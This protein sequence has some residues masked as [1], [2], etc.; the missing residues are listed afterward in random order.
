MGR[1]RVY[2][3]DAMALS[4]RPLRAGRRRFLGAAAALA[5]A[6]AARAGAEPPIADAH[7][8]IGMFSSRLRSLRAEMEQAG[9]TLLA[10]SIVGDTPW[11]HRTPRGI[12]Q[13]AEPKPGEQA[14]HF[15]RRLAQVRAYLSRDGLAHIEAPAD[16]EAARGGAP[17]VVIAL[18]GAGL[19][20]DGL[21]LLDEAYAG[22]LRH[23]QLVHYIRNAL[24]D[25]QTERP[26]HGG[27]TDLGAD[28]IRACNRLGM[29]VDLA[30][31][32][33]PAIDRALE[34]SAVPP[35]W[36]HSSISATQYSW[37]QSSSL[38]RLLYIDYARKI[39]QRGGAI[40]LWS[41]K[42][43]VGSVPSGYADELLRMV[44]AVGPEH[45]MFGTDLDGVGAFGTMD[46][47]ADLR[48]VAD[49]LLRR[50]VDAK[51]LRALCF[52]NYARCLRAAMQGRQA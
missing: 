2:L 17:R 32:T 43:T 35:I 18:E 21:E 37:Q 19:A 40:G 50:G 23:L 33:G 3:R 9:V 11:T 44:D 42:R 27:L 30:H 45:V 36:S 29:L 5:F 31:A 49:E 1:I 16:L 41:L 14:A 13:R 48:A 12:E 7:S 10:W 4:T 22:G 28:V 6:P 15:R 20:A 25:F 8:H 47:L 24:G 38:S 46:K 51:T 39:A 26:E 52:G 34:V